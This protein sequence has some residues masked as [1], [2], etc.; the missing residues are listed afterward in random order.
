[1]KF[2]PLVL[3]FS[4]AVGGCAHLGP[5]SLKGNRLD[6]NL[7]IQQTNDQELLLNL[8]RLKYR[9]RIY[10]MNVERVVSTME[11]NRGFG[12]GAVFP[13]DVDPT[14]SISPVS[15]SFNEKPSLFYSPLE[16]EKFVRQMLTSISLETILLLT[17]SG[18]SIERVLVMTLQGMNDLRNAPTASGPTPDEAPEYLAFREVARALR[19][20]QTQGLID[21]GR[22]GSANGGNGDFEL[23]IAPQASANPD[24]IRLRELLNLD[25]ALNSYRVVLG[26]GA[27]DRQTIAVST[28]AMAG[29]L[30]YLSQAVAVPAEDESAGRVTVTRESGG[31]RFDWSRVLANVLAVQVAADQPKDAAITVPYRGKWFYVA[32]SDLQSKTSFS[33]LAQ[34]MSL[35]AGPQAV[36]GTALSFSVG[37]P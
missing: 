1:M 17:R 31:A 12:L 29:V 13:P 30:Y 34:L 16:G 6:Y 4:L 21:F 23:R 37:S 25:P 5:E 24:A 19:A 2:F 36:S 18:W 9:D 35:Q 26:I 27:S 11:F 10:F 20:L 28:R 3:V 14:F 32:D 8:V 15:G 22:G 7:A 33:L